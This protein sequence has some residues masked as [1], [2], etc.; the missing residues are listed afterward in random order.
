MLNQTSHKRRLR[1]VIAALGTVAAI[2]AMGAST[3]ASA[4]DTY[5]DRLDGSD[6]SAECRKS[7]PCASIKRGL[8]KAGPGDT[9]FI[10]GDPFAYP[11]PV[12]LGKGKSLVASDFSTNPAID[13]SGKAM[14]DTG[15]D[16]RPAVT[17]ASDAGRIKGLF[18]N[19]TTKPLEIH[20]SVRVI[21]NM[22]LEDD[23]VAGAM[24][25]I[26]ADAHGRAVIKTNSLHVTPHHNTTQLGIRNWS[27]TA[28]LID[29]NT[30]EGFSLSIWTRGRPTIHDNRIY[31]THPGGTFSGEGIIT[32][33]NATLSENQLLVPDTSGNPVRGILVLGNARLERNIV[34]GFDNGI[35]LKDTP[36]P[37]ELNGDVIRTIGEGGTVGLRATDSTD[38]PGVSDPH[39]TNVTLVGLGQKLAL[40]SVRMRLASSIVADSA[41]AAQSISGGSTCKIT[42]SRGPFTGNA[43]D[44]CTNYQTTKDPLFAA[45]GYHLTAASPMIDKGSKRPPSP[46]ARD[47]DGD[48]R[49]LDGPDGGDCDGSGRRDIGA[50]EYRC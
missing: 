31:G 16:P 49:A 39:A 4:H 48:L 8:A 17:V 25:D 1:G 37:V 5:V 45:D 7:S 33:G 11:T 36:K 21:E 3:T 40:D 38:S 26:A 23:V 50:D 15:A 29:N 2:A 35:E 14:I 20:A 42:R 19:S 47:F 27:K 24:I 32:R 10:G 9:V 13:T 6:G 22:F 28:P 44:G 43:V 41:L 46:G 18:I 34:S 30:L 12:T